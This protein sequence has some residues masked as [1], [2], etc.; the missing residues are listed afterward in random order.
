MTSRLTSAQVGF[1]VVV[2]A[3]GGRHALCPLSGPVSTVAHHLLQVGHGGPRPQFLEHVVAARRAGEL[4]HARL[5]VL[6]VAEGDGLGRARLLA[7][8]LDLTVLHRAARVASAILARD[9]ALHAHGALLHDA[10]LPHRHVGVE[11]DVERRRPRVVEPVEPAHVVRA[12]VAAVARPHAAVVDLG[13]QPLAGVIGRVDR[14][15]RL[16]R[17]DLTVL[18][19]HRQE[20]VLRIV[21]LAFLPAL[22]A[23]PVLVAPV[24]HLLLAHHRDIVLGDAGDHTGLAPGAEVDVHGHAPPVLRILDRGVHA[25]VARVLGC[26]P[27]QL[28]LPRRAEGDV[29][30]DLAI[31]LVLGGLR[32]GERAAR[33]RSRRAA[34]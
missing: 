19:E 13:V 22:Q 9:G 27:A 16:A 10:E 33:R 6:Q 23:Q 21:V 7:R 32:N 3:L 31:V 8:G 18:A 14:T 29:L 25:R 20:E 12:V 11:L 26:P 28:E 34:P 15:D 17:R 2:V 5:P 30:S 4:R 24:G 1:G